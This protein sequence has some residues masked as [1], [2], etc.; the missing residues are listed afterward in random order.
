MNFCSKCGAPLKVQQPSVEAVTPTA[1]AP[2]AP[3]TAEKV[4][5]QEKGEKEEK[6][7]RHEKMEKEERYEKRGVEYMGALIGGLVLIFLGLV[8]YLTITAAIRWEAVWAL[9][10]IVLGIM[11]IVGAAYAAVM[12]SRRHPKT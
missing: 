10:F 7:E 2:P 9:F 4:E 5:K 1:P 12:A 3:S 11:I 8:F 6:G